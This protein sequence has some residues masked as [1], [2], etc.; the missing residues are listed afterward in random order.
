MP[1]CTIEQE[2][3]NGRTVLRVAGGSFDRASAFA[4]RDALRRVSCEDLVLDFTQV[5]DF[6][7]LGV[8]T[9]AHGILGEERRMRLRGLRQ[10]QLRIFRYFG[11]DVEPPAP[12]ADVV[13]IRS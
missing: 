8:A 13:S 11:V 7:D 5:R 1:G 6:A 12:D 4:L 9:L 10:H 2:Q 3:E